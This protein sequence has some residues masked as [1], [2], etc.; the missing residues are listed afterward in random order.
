M[1]RTAAAVLAV[2][3]LAFATADAAD[4][5]YETGAGTDGDIQTAGPG[6]VDAGVFSDK[7]ISGIC[8]DCVFP[9]IVSRDEMTGMNT[10]RIPDGAAENQA[11]GICG[12]SDSSGNDAAGFRTSFWEPARLIELERMSGCSSVLGAVRFPF[13][14]LNQGAEKRLSQSDAGVAGRS[15]RHYHY[16]SFPIM[17]ML[18]MWI[19]ARC[20]P[21]GYMDLDVMYLSEIDPTWNNDEIAFFTHAEAALIASPLGVSSCTPDVFA[22]NAGEPIQD[23]YWCAGAWGTLFPTSGNVVSRE[24]IL[25]TTSLQ[26]ARALYEMHYRGIEWRSMGD[27][28]LCGGVLSEYFPKTQWRFQLFH[29]IAETDD[30]HVMGESAINWGTNRIVPA[31]GEDPVYVLW[32]W[33]DCCNTSS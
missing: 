23:L 33:L 20:N 4:P 30:N 24:G 12:C 28:A 7:L 29:P 15:F 6:C 17:T 27:D 25:T 31:S 9:I 5:P 16:Y 14:R 2:F 19:P 10:G 8:W 26:A 22:S 11:Q 13:N 21:G 3:S 18:N 32:R 1:K